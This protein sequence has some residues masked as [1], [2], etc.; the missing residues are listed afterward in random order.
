[1]GITY[2]WPALGSRADP[3]FA[4]LQPY[5]A[6]AGI[7]LCVASAAVAA[8]GAPSDAAFGRGLLQLL[9]VGLPMAA[10]FYAMRSP[11]SRRFGTALLLL[12]IAW[13]LTALG[14]SSLSVPYT[15]GR[16]AYWF[17]LPS[18]FYLLLAFPHGQIAAAWTG[19]CSTPSSRSP[20][21]CSSRPPSSWRRSR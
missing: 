6:S 15:I 10:G 21:C 14:E 9:V 19:P 16:A 2:A 20:S 4:A 11:A 7:A 5:A 18:I 12:G 8:S 13:S 1:M 3:A 17:L